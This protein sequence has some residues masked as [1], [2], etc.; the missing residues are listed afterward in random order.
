MSLESNR[1]DFNLPNSLDSDR[2]ISPA[3]A[4]EM[5]GLSLATLHRMWRQG[6]GPRR[7]QISPRRLGVRLRDLKAFLDARAAV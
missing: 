4:A 3:M 5:M 6:G 7:I 2:L 1:S